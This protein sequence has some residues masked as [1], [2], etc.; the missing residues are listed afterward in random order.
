M[1]CY[2][3]LKNQ[4]KIF[5]NIFVSEVAIQSGIVR[6]ASLFSTVKHVVMKF[7]KDETIGRRV[8]TG[9]WY[10]WRKVLFVLELRSKFWVSVRPR[11]PK[12][13][14]GQPKMM[15]ITINL[16]PKLTFVRVY[17]P[18]TDNQ[19]T[20]T[21]RNCKLVVRWTTIYITLLE[22]EKTIIDF[23]TND[24]VFGWFFIVEFYHY[25]YLEEDYFDRDRMTMDII[26]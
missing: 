25:K 11:P 9:N 26:S 5:S 12:K 21:T 18:R 10:D 22:H 20:W 14:A 1:V 16:W 13:I 7:V 3:N 2:T 8:H 24:S 15:W 19:K 6:I 23:N 4:N 17:I